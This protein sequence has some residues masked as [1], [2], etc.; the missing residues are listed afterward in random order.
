MNTCHT[1]IV[2]GGQ[3]GLAAGYYLKKKQ[4]PFL[5]L[6]ASTQAGSSW[7]ARYDSLRLFTFSRYNN[8]PGIDFPGHKDRF[9]TK[10]EVADYLS[11]YADKLQLP[12]LLNH[13][14]E[15]LTKEGKRFSVRASG[16]TFSCDNVIVATGPFQTPFIPSFHH[17]LDGSIFQLHSS[18]YKN[19]SQLAQG[20]VLVVGAGNSGVQIVEELVAT[21][22]QVYFSYGGKLNTMANNKL[23]QRLIFGSGLTSLSKSSWLG[24]LIHKRQEP[25]MGTNLEKLFASE[26][27]HLVGRAMNAEGRTIKFEGRSVENKIASIVWATGFKPD[28]SWINLAILDERGFPIEKRG[29]SK[30]PGLYFLGLAWMHSRN[31]GLLGGVKE[32]AAF[33]T[34]QIKI[35]Q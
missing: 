20:D 9:P 30:I 14:V 23:T 27:L 21:S 4:V 31:S 22:R 29:V 26:N 13:S 25:I 18:Q 2:G 7:S 35:E 12:M 24:S 34:S 3:A 10:D 28:F 15:L 6:E 16:K 5:I 8:L 32:D 1:I 33:V 11:S 19:P 17:Q